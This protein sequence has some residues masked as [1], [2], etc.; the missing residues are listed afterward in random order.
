MTLDIRE[1]KQLYVGQLKYIC[2]VILYLYSHVYHSNNDYLSYMYMYM[3]VAHRLVVM[4]V[5][6]HWFCVL[7]A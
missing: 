1:C 7:L 6:V 2:V 4:R 3:Y 5:K